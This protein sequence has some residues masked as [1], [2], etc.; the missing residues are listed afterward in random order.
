MWVSSRRSRSARPSMP[1]AR[2]SASVSR[3]VIRRRRSSAPFARSSL[4]A[5]TRSAARASTTAIAPPSTR[6]RRSVGESPSQRSLRLMA[7]HPGA[8]AGCR[9]GVRLARA[10]GDVELGLLAGGEARP[11]PGGDRGHHRAGIGRAA[12]LLQLDRLLALVAGA[13]REE[14]QPRALQDLG[15]G[16]RQPRLAAGG[17][18]PASGLARGVAGGH[19]VLGQGAQRGGDVLDVGLVVAHH[20]ARVA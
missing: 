8:R 14:A 9:V 1:M 6:A 10:Q 7:S 16:N 2:G 11:G 5:V 19:P 17:V 12:P 4:G 20:G 13:G 15:G 3:L 18:L